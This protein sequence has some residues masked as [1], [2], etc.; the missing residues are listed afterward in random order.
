LDRDGLLIE[1]AGCFVNAA[2]I[3]LKLLV[4]VWGDLSLCGLQS[5]SIEAHYELRNHAYSEIELGLN[6]HGDVVERIV[7][8]YLLSA[9][10]CSNRLT[11]FGD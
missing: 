5:M 10:S 8:G 11:L 1:A 3:L 6:W 2:D 7:A 9:V 4:V